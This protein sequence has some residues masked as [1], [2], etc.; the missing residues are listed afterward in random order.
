MTITS[1]P[2]YRWPGHGSLLRM[3]HQVE[4]FCQRKQV[5]SQVRAM[6][7]PGA[8]EKILQRHER[9]TLLVILHYLLKNNITFMW[10]KLNQKTGGAPRVRFSQAACG[11]LPPVR[12]QR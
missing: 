4:Q 11:T 1:N 7:S 2:P 9:I 10:W 8:G 3:W 5:S 12:D 6:L